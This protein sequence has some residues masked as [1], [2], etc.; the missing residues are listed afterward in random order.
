MG[1]FPGGCSGLPLQSR[2]PLWRTLSWN[3]FRTLCRNS[4]PPD[5]LRRY[6]LDVNS[7]SVPRMLPLIFVLQLVALF[8]M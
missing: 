7:A 1:A 2:Q 5:W 6:A 8:G 4:Y 3:A